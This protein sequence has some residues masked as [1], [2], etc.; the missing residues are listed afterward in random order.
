MTV[1]PGYKQTEIG[2]IPTE[3]EIRTIASIAAPKRN[4][5]VG[6]PFGSDLVSKDYVRVGV[7]VLRGQNMGVPFVSGDFVFVSE[8]KADIL[9]ANTARPQD[10]IFTQRGTLGQLSLVPNEPFDRYL[11]SQCPSK[12]L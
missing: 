2:L 10:I 1:K 7:P 8:E 3:W 6:G 5:I 9:C 11:V 4:A 12:N